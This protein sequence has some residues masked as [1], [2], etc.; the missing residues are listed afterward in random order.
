MAAPFWGNVGLRAI[1]MA[2]DGL[3][4]RQRVTANNIANIDTPGYKAQRVGFEAQLRRAL[5]G[6]DDGG[7]SLST[8]DTDHLGGAAA[9]RA[10]LITVDHENND[11]RND[12]NNVDIDLEMTTLAETSLRYQALSQ[13]AGSRFASLKSIVR[14]SR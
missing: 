3:S 13:M 7:L 4:M 1:S 2:L 10:A 14:D 11:L 6:E 9:E 12:T 8:T 5:R